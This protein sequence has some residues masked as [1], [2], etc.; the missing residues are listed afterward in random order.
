MKGEQESIYTVSDGMVILPMTFLH[1]YAVAET[2]VIT[3]CIE[4]GNNSV[5]LW[6][7]NYPQKGTVRVTRHILKFLGPH[8]IFGMGES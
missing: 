5:S 2:R 6:T 8:H 4:V 7:A 1:I 3:F